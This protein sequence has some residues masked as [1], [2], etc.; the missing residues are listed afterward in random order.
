[1]NAPSRGHEQLAEFTGETDLTL[2][3]LARRLRRAV[4]QCTAG[5]STLCELRAGRSRMPELP[6]AIALAVVAKIPV[7]AWVEKPRGKNK[8]G[9]PNAEPLK[10]IES[11]GAKR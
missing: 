3:D 6:L 7:D 2:K 10:V 4:P 9:P 1:M 11:E 5:A 8:F